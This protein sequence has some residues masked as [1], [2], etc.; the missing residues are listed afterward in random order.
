[1]YLEEKLDLLEKY[2]APLTPPVPHTPK[3]SRAEK[4]AREEQEK[5]QELLNDIVGVFVL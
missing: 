5:A 2:G 1:M 3:E 4:K